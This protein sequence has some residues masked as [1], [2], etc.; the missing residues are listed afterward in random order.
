MATLI[1]AEGNGWR[2]R[3]DARCHEAR[4][5][6]CVCICGGRFHGAGQQAAEALRQQAAEALQEGMALSASVLEE[7]RPQGATDVRLAPVQLRLLEGGCRGGQGSVVPEPIENA[8]AV[9]E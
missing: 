9:E 6:R 3:C 5:P 8:R 7:L 2:R 4:R 1:R